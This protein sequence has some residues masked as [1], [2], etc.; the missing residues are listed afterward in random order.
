MIQLLAHPL[1]HGAAGVWD[2]ILFLAAFVI[3]VVIFI[4]LALRDKKQD[5]QSGKDKSKDA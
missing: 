1:L 2:E 4:W 5:S 3:S